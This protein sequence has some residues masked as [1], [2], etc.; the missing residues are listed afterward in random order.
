MRWVDR[1]PAPSGVAYYT[2]TYTHL[3]VL[4]CQQ[5][6]GARPNQHN[7][8]TVF[9]PDLRQRFNAKCGYCEQRFERVGELSSSVD[10]FRPLCHS[11][12]LAYEWNNW[13]SSCKRC[14]F[15]KDDQWPDTGYV[16]PCATALLEWPEEYFDYAH[17]TGEIVAKPGL[18]HASQR[19]A[20]NTIDDLELN[21]TRLRESRFRLM[22]SLVQDLLLSKP[23]PDRLAV[24]G[25]YQ[26]PSQPHSGVV[27]MF[28]KLLQR[29]G[30]I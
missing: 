25:R 4:Y 13:V 17:L 14:N 18:T 26:E 28:A 24:V 30:I 19:K 12:N 11:P 2:N 23:G 27:A 6:I 15:A 5:G 22:G 21:V 1:G 16:D 10:H 8:W 3:W 7:Y 9:A 20:E 29:S